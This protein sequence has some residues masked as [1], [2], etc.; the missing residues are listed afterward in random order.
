MPS[1]RYV[2]LLI[3]AL[4]RHISN[5]KWNNFIKL[6]LL[7]SQYVKWAAEFEC[8]CHAHCFSPLRFNSIYGVICGSFLLSCLLWD[9]A[10]GIL[11]FPFVELCPCLF[12]VCF[13]LLSRS[14][15]IAPPRQ[16]SL[17]LCHSVSFFSNKM[18]DL[19]FLE[20][21]SPKE[22]CFINSNLTLLKAF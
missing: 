8:I 19:T 7:M 16:P 12:F 5:K 10:L 18:V 21:P 22:P 3:Y 11:M 17:L 14:L 4:V 15:S 6:K 13:L 9:E 20:M 2:N 1:D